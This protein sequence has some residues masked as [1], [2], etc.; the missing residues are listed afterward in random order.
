[1]LSLQP[2]NKF[3]SKA[4]AHCGDDCLSDNIIFQEKFF[5]CTGCKTVYQILQEQGLENYYNIEETPGITKRN[6]SSK[7][8]D[9]VDN[10]KV[11]EQI[12]EFTDGKISRIRIF[13]PSIHCSSCIWLLEN[14]HKLSDGIVQ[15]RVDF[16]KKQAAIV[17]KE[18][19][20]D[21]KEVL[22]LLD[23]IGY[24][25]D[26]V[27]SIEDKKNTP[28]KNKVSKSLIYKI[29]VAGFS[30]GNIMLLSFPEYLDVLNEITPFHADLFRYISFLFVL[31]VV[32]YSA[33]DYYISAY[34]SIRSGFLNI[35]VP[36]A[37]GIITLFLRSSI[38]AFVFHKVGY[39]DSLAGLLFFL[40]IGKWFQD[41]T[42]NALS[43][44]RDFRSF[45]PLAFKVENGDQQVFKTLEEIEIDDIAVIRNGEVVPADGIL[46][47][48]NVGVDY[49]FVT[50]ESVPVVVKQGQS[51]FAG[52]QVLGSSARIQLVKAVSNSYLIKLWNERDDLD[53]SHQ[54]LLN[55]IDKISQ[56]FTLGVLTIASLAAIYWG[57]STDW[58]KA[59][60]IFT[61]VLIVACPCA[62]A[63][64][65]PYTFGHAIR[66]LGK[67][68]V[69]FKNT[70][71]I[72]K[73]ASITTLVFDKTGTLTDSSQAEVEFISAQ[74]APIAF[75]EVRKITENSTHPLSSLLA[76]QYA[77]LNT[78][79]SLVHFEE[80]VGKGIKASIDS[81]SYLL[82]SYDFLMENSIRL[83]KSDLKAPKVYLA[84]NGVYQGVFIFYNKYRENIFDQL[85]SLKNHYKIVV[86]SGDEDYENE[87]LRLELGEDVALKFNQTPFDK[88]NYIKELQD[89]G[90]I[91]A[92]FGDG[93]NDAG[94]LSQSDAG[95]SIIE[96]I[97]SFSPASDII[98]KANRL[99]DLPRIFNFSK[100]SLKLLKLSLMFSLFYN[101]IGLSFA[102]SGNLTP[103]VAA[104][105]MPLS[106]VSVVGFVSLGIF[107]IARRNKLNK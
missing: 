13:L 7:N 44:D 29:G 20:I 78:T 56:K 28:Q 3:V 104:V 101:S 25:P 57:F 66:F 26:L 61:A 34:K 8:F 14:L 73:L 94:A 85:L 6:K 72:E 92:M 38:D 23:K 53:S 1:M 52:G 106:S 83:E 59:V 90:E 86:L 32:L 99:E 64:A 12:Y 67:I 75:E 21:L 79:K 5:C 89:N 55:T 91:V 96:N 30:F 33:K 39:F 102:V 40:L 93:L 41:K 68:D 58:G 76:S 74:I 81:K 18:D 100:Q 22:N 107:F 51:I 71:V 45:F 27:N 54:K 49:S 16:M 87:K 103:L 10:E 50:G 47:D 4:C 69:F 80:I 84:I 60:N 19:I 43:F 65:A 17:F 11:K 82:G 35:D 97:G 42:Y 2:K 62:L 88:R 46:L 63:L 105:L 9:Y 77:H 70:S 36:I 37:I 24:T 31:P 95:I 48:T 98:I 15:S